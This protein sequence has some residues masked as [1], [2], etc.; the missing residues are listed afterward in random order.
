M[1]R[2]NHL[3]PFERS[4]IDPRLHPVGHFEYTTVHPSCGPHSGNV[5]V[6]DFLQ[7]TVVFVRMGGSE[8]RVVLHGTIR[9]VATDHSQGRKDLVPEGFLPALIGKLLGNH[10][11]CKKHE[12]VILVFF[13][14]SVGGLHV[15][16]AHQ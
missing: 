2:R 7:G 15:L 6:R 10:S 9:A 13:L 8:V 4:A 1:R 3:L 14:R 5:V 16:D 12:V 11:L